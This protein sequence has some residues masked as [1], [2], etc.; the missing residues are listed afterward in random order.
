MFEVGVCIPQVTNQNHHVAFVR[1]SDLELRAAVIPDVIQNM[2]SGVDFGRIPYKQQTQ[3]PMV[4]SDT[5]KQ[6]H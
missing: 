1:F 2:N 5:H 3:Y 4:T 6:K